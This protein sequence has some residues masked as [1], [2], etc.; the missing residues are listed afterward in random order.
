M[1]RYIENL[2]EIC[3]GYMVYASLYIVYTNKYTKY[4]FF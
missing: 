1:I 2:K 3:H 4:L